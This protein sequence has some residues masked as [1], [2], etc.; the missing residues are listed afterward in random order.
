MECLWSF[1]YVGASELP[2]SPLLSSSGP[3]RFSIL[4]QSSTWLF[5]PASIL[6]V[7]LEF[8]EPCLCRLWIVH[9]TSPF[10]ISIF[11]K[12][13]SPARR[14]QCWDHLRL[15]SSIC[16]LRSC[17]TLPRLHVLQRARIHKVYET[18]ADKTHCWGR[19]SRRQKVLSTH[20]RDFRELF[21][22]YWSRLF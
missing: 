13:P 2:T 6:A 10:S 12:S 7:P 16:I 3:D 14:L 20:W 18:F 21:R 4:L 17:C 9:G 5:Y 11:P 22:C 19:W 1:W 8:S 15:H